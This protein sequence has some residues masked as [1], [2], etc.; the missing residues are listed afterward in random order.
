MSQGGWQASIC[1]KLSRQRRVSCGSFIALAKFLFSRGGMMT[2]MQIN[3]GIP[4]KDR[5]E[6]ADGLS[7]LL[8]DSYTLYVKTH[9]FHWNV[10][11]PMFQPLHQMFEQQY[12]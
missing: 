7:R 6:I 9:N 4:E 3:T 12:Q 2:G 1:A 11:G 10:T 8:A 5:N